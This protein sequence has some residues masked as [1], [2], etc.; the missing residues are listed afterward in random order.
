[1][2]E[3][4]L[5]VSPRYRNTGAENTS[6]TALNACIDW[7]Q[8]TFKNEILLTKILDLIGMQRKDFF[9]SSGMYGYSKGLYHEGITILYRAHSNEMGIHLQISGT[10]CRIL[11][12]RE[13]FNWVDF[14]KRIHEYSQDEQIEINI[15]RLDI[16]LDDQQGIFS[17]KEVIKK[18]KRGELTSKFK[19]AIRI[20]TIDIETGKSEGNTVYFGRA[21]S[22]IRIRM[23]EKNH[24][25]KYKYKDLNIDEKEVW[26]RIELQLRNER[27]MKMF[28]ILVNK[29]D[30]NFA[31]EVKGVLSSYLQFRN[32]RTDK[33]KSRWPIWRKWEKFIGEVEKIKLTVSE[34]EKSL[35]HSYIHVEKQYSA[36]LATFERA[37]LSVDMLLRTG[38]EKMTEKH[39]VKI[40]QYKRVLDQLKNK[41]THKAPEFDKINKN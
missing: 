32:R 14:L 40:E 36:L 28:L 19:K 31:K 5:H 34:K 33:N 13:G 1:M 8:V 38:E 2:Q 29:D 16:A 30:H 24:E 22:N 6:K 27:A 39:L 18:V 10:G 4:K 26:N 15:S 20:E 3:P 37:G 41:K 7:L 11:E 35:I 23:Y 21:S 17:I 12:Q 25:I 9:Q